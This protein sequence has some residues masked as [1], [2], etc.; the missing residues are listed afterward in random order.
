MKCPVYTPTARSLAPAALALAVLGPASAHAT[1]LKLPG[2]PVKAEGL[3]RALVVAD[4]DGDGNADLLVQHGEQLSAFSSEGK[5]LKGWPVSPASLNG[6]PAGQPAAPIGGTLVGMPAA[7]DVDGDRKGEIALCLATPDGAARLVVL[8]V[9][10]SLQPGFPLTLARGVSVGPSLADVN[11]DGVLDVVA[12]TRDG[13]L[14]VV[15]GRAKPVNG[16]PVSIGSEVSSTISFGRLANGAA[17]A[18]V[19]GTLD[20]RLHA[21]LSDGTRARGF[22]VKSEFTISGAPALADIDDDGEHEVIFSSQDYKVY[23]VNADGSPVPGFPVNAGYRIYGGPAVGDVDG[24]GNP[25]IVVGAYNGEVYAWSAAGKQL[26][27]FPVSAGAKLSMPVLLADTDRDRRDEIFV[28]NG[29]QVYGWRGNGKALDDFPL[30][31]PGEQLAPPALADFVRDPTVELVYGAS[32]ELHAVRMERQGELPGMNLAWPQAGHDAT[33]QGRFGPSPGRYRNVRIVPDTPHHGEALKAAWEFGDLDGD[34]EPR[35]RIRW[36]L[37]GK[38]VRDLD[39]KAS[40]PG[41]LVNKGGRWK[42][43]MQAPDDWDLYKDGPAAHVAASA[44]VTVA[45]TPPGALKIAIVPSPARTTDELAVKIVE[46]APDIDGEKVTYRQRW[47]RDGDFAS[48]QPKVP[49]S[50]TKKGERWSVIVTPSDGTDDGPTATAEV[51]IL[52]TAPV[53]PKIAFEPETPRIETELRVVTVEPATDADGDKL[54]YHYMFFVNG[55][56][57]ALPRERATMP[58]KSFRRGDTVAVEVRAAD[59]EVEGELVRAETKI[60]NSA[61]EAPVV[62]IAPAKPGTEEELSTGLTAGARDPDGDPVK[63]RVQWRRN[64]ELF[65]APGLLRVGGEETKKGDKWSVEVVASDDALEGPAGT[66]EVVIGNSPPTAPRVVADRPRPTV[67]ESVFLSFAEKSH[68]PDGDEVSYEYEW[69]VDGKNASFAKDKVSLAPGEFRKNQRIVV[70]V[71]PVDG[72]G[73]RGR[74]GQVE[75]RPRNTPPGLCRVGFADKEPTFETGV[76]AVIVTPAPDKDGDNIVYRYRWHRDGV[77]V[78]EH[79]DKPVLKPGEVHRFEEWRVVAIPFDGEE[80]GPPAEAWVPVGDVAPIAAKIAIS[81]AHPTVLTGLKCDIVEPAKDP[82]GDA[83]TLEYRWT[84]DGQPFPLPASAASVPGTLV[85]QGQS[86]RCEVS[87]F[88]GKFVSAPAAAMATIENAAPTAPSAA[89]EPKEPRAGDDLRCAVTGD[90]TD[91]DGD[92]VSY[93]YRWTPPAGVAPGTLEDPSR[94]PAKFVRKTQSWKC[95][96][97]ASDGKASA[98]GASAATAVLNT[99]PRAPRVRLVPAEPTAGTELRCEI[100]AP[101]VDAD[102]DKLGYAFGW[103]RNDEKQSFAETSNGVPSRMIKAGDRWRCFAAASDGEAT[104]AQGRSPEA[105][106]R[107]PPAAAAATK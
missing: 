29:D 16:F 51:L 41:N 52:N 76:K 22:P 38:A 15:T 39:D 68:D 26:A 21:V 9:D 89:I 65:G 40:V 70:R 94:I 64:G 3:V 91:P 18:L 58:A 56:R 100:T 63:Y 84:R 19:A 24:D 11:A 78:A 62:G 101:S 103:L 13:A 66:A 60:A 79:N 4:L 47:L 55:K 102:G 57:R 82:D 107:P 43:T 54:A 96:V 48:D 74:V 44:V 5:R 61:P 25:D 86:W 105:K 85:R 14:W 59:D 99:A 28:A 73:A 72:E 27:G 17:P 36:T 67:D 83:L 93:E 75:L 35:A 30:R 33:R 77:H 106:V 49:A 20:G 90:A 31:A 92:K 7:G 87:A 6:A 81:P 88:D 50:A 1:P 69:I 12:G 8:R 53:P 98:T 71:T 42:A 97:I 45:N 2:F 23:A 80:E 46:E 10:G 34:P 32:G 95:D 37:D 104:G